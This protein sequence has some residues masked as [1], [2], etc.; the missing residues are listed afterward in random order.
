MPDLRKTRKNIKF[1]LTVLL[2]V[3]VVAAVV[4]FSPLVGSQQSRRQ[5]LNQLWAELQAKTRE[6]K[7]LT[8]IDQ[9]V[10]T[11]NRQITEFYQKRF[12]AKDSQIVAELGKLAT[13]N[14][15][16]IAQANY[17]VKDEATA[18]LLPFE[19]EAS[20]SGN[21][22]SLARFI[23]AVERDDMIFLINGVSL[24]GEQTGPIKLE[25]KLETYLKAGA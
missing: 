17:K 24:G 14:G 7:P 13:E 20:L 21:Y 9:R 5:E 22:A 1:A 8:N 11:A 15:V 18:R 16:T 12:P 3:D 6:V 23:N 19:I 4:L 10:K 2:G 25:M